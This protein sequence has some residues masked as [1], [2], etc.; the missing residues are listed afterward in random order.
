VKIDY[1][2]KRIRIIIQMSKSEPV[3]E[4]EHE[5][6]AYYL[7]RCYRDRVG[8]NCV[9]DYTDFP[10]SRNETD[11]PW[12]RFLTSVLPFAS[13]DFQIAFGEGKNS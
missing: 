4:T 7:G 5:Y 3:F 6:M 13:I 9:G 8:D 12:D 11:F 1:N 10:S 2:I